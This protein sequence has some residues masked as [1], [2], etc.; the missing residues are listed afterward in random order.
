MISQT[1]GQPSSFDHIPNVHDDDWGKGLVEMLNVDR[2]PSCNPPKLRDF[3]FCDHCKPNNRPVSIFDQGLN[4]GVM[5]GV[6][7]SQFYPRDS[8]HYHRWISLAEHVVR[9]SI[10][11]YGFGCEKRIA[12]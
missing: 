1:P 10:M 12:I 11:A 3:W 5:Y 4:D 7:D 9:T 8:T 2:F 6:V